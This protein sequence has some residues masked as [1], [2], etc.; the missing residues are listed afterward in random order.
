MGGGGA[1]GAPMRDETDMSR[2]LL[3]LSLSSERLL[4]ESRERRSLAERERVGE[5]GAP[6]ERGVD[7]ELP[8]AVCG[9]ETKGCCCDKREGPA[10]AAVV[11]EEEVEAEVRRVGIFAR[12][13]SLQS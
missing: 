11:A 2:V 6:G 8:G 3:L 12:T 9:A 13:D 5:V 7:A 4:S 10:V 1:S